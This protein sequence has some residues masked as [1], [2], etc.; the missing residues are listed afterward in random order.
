MSSQRKHIWSNPLIST[1][2]TT[3]LRLQTMYR[4]VRNAYTTKGQRVKWRVSDSADGQ[5]DKSD[6]AMRRLWDALEHIQCSP[7][8]LELTNDINCSYES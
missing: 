3:C 7:L 2:Q 1:T 6:S 8:E 4:F 5:S